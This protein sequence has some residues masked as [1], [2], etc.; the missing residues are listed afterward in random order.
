[1]KADYNEILRRILPDPHATMG[2][3]PDYYHRQVLILVSVGMND[4]Q[5]IYASRSSFRLGKVEVINIVYYLYCY[6][7]HYDTYKS[8]CTL[9]MG[10]YS[11]L[12]RRFES[13]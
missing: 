1:M 12:Y 7:L 3:S 4:L 13:S 8:Y 9:T 10:E 5:G 6:S 11:D 2:E